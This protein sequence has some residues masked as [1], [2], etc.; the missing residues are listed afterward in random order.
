MTHLPVIVGFG[1]YNAAGRSSFHHGFRRTV[2][3]TLDDAKRNKTLLGLA[4]LMK[5]VKHQDGQYL[6]NDGELL[7]ADQVADRYR[8][9]I[10]ENT[11][12][13]RIHK[14]HFDVDKV[15]STQD[16]ELSE[17]GSTEFTVRRRDLPNPIPANWQVSTVDDKTV[18]VS[19]AGDMSIKMES[20]R[21]FDVQSGGTLPTGFEPAEQYASRFHP[22]GLQMAILA[23]S[24]ALN[25]MGFSWQS[26]MDKVDPD[27]VAVFA[28]SG[29]GQTDE[30]GLGGYMQARLRSSRVTSKQMAMGLNSMPADFINAYVCG[31]VGTTGAVTGACA[32]FLY[33]LRLGVDDIAAGRHRVAICGISEAPVT[34]EVI[35]GFASMSALATDERLAKL[36]G[37]E[38]ADHRRASRP[39]GENCGFTMG[40]SAQYFVLMDDQ[41]ALELG[42]EIYAAVPDV[43]INADGFKKSISSP[44]AGNYITM[45][46]AVASAQAIVGEEA[47]RQRSFIQAHGS[48]T[49]QNRITES[50]IFDKVAKAFDIQ[51]WPVTA[52]KAFVGH[53]LGPASGDQLASALGTF[54]D[55]IIPGIK[56]TER[57]ADDVVDENLDILLQDKSA[58]MDV[59]FLNSKGFGGN[60]ATATVLSPRI[61]EQMMAK[62]YGDEAMKE[63]RHKRESVRA[64]ANAYDQQATNGELNVI[65]NFGAGIIDEA[66]IDL[67]N[68]ALSI[69]EFGNPIS[70]DFENPY[71]D[72]T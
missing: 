47:I 3:G 41:L 43:F 70:L 52:V 22:R 30:Y 60:N 31:S 39:F 49:P 23:A 59:A 63:Y 36:D 19:I 48:S 64:Q 53:P 45:A 44:G 67:N 15:S 58:L 38:Q 37:I 69:P 10:E 34:P 50:I 28:S 16:L 12:I 54:A 66:N 8:A 6:D 4:C 46:K 21:V 9:T 57:V 26:V 7:T 56:T 17:L 68:G 2:L 29:L 27:Q 13:R 33:N 24:D 40:E 55:D 35:E 61:A 18:K 51:D 20:F 71:A 14:A 65:Y 1:G 42:A 11:L 25:S 72:M 5:L 32:S 62:R